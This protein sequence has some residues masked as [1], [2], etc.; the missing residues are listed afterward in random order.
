[1]PSRAI[2]APAV[3]HRAQQCAAP[4]NHAAGRAGRGD[5]DQHGVARMRRPWAAKIGSGPETQGIGKSPAAIADRR[6]KP[7]AAAM[8]DQ[9]RI[10]GHDAR[11]KRGFLDSAAGK[12]RRAKQIDRSGAAAFGDHPEL[13]FALEDEGVGQMSGLLEHR[14]GPALRTVGSERHGGNNALADAVVIILQEQ[15]HPP[16]MQDRKGIGIEAIAVIGQVDPARIGVPA[17]IEQIGPSSLRQPVRQCG[18]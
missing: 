7:P 11:Q 18:A 5:I 4:R 8:L 1:M 12:G 6:E 2:S 15:C 16:L 17:Q 3:L 14:L 13:A 10:A 9:R